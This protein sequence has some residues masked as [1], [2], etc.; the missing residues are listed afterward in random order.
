MNVVNRLYVVRADWDHEAGVWVA[1]SEDIPGLATG[2]DTFEALFDK[3]RIVV[4]ELLEE[5]GLLPPS[6]GGTVDVP[7]SLIAQRVEHVCHSV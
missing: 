5:N 3:L 7:F 6:S 2:G 1:Y 4:P